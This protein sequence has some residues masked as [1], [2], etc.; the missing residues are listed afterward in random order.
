MKWVYLSEEQRQVYLKWMGIYKKTKYDTN[1]FD[2]L[3]SKGIAKPDEIIEKDIINCYYEKFAENN[4]FLESALKSED[5][6]IQISALYY[7][8]W[9]PKK[10]FIETVQEMKFLDQSD[11]SF[12]LH[13]LEF[14]KT[15]QE[16]KANQ[17]YYER[18]KIK[19]KK[20]KSTD[21]LK[22]L[23]KVSLMEIE[24]GSLLITFIDKSKGGELLDRINGIRRQFAVELGIIIPPIRIRDNMNLYENEYKIII[25]EKIVGEYKLYPEK[26]LLMTKD[27]IKEKFEGVDVKEP[28]F[29]LPARWINKA[30]KKS[31][32][33]LGY[34][35][36]DA[37]AVFATHLKEIVRKYAYELLIRQDIKDITDNLKKTYPVIIEGI[38]PDKISYAKVHRLLQNLLKN[39]MSIKDQVSIFEIIGDDTNKDSSIEELTDL[40]GQSTN[41]LKE[42]NE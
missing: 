14:L 20:D 32:K 26:L 21:N 5:P 30:D 31:A 3:L 10:T 28:A 27:T 15:Y 16:E 13:I 1:L 23:L 29:G 4:Y 11:E 6:K 42:I 40:I 33:S 19:S 17:D 35:V 12:R 38:I 39:G 2:F 9:Y 25:K 22:N 34:T 41:H 8:I 24:I 18:E 36:V 7:L 37:T